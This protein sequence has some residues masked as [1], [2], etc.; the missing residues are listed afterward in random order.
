MGLDAV[1]QESVVCG[2][3]SDALIL[4]ESEASISA[5]VL[6]LTVKPAMR[7]DFQARCPGLEY[8][9]IK[10]SWCQIRPIRPAADGGQMRTRMEMLSRITG[11]YQLPKWLTERGTRSCPWRRRVAISLRLR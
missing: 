10:P 7:T 11:C 1:V 3:L 9:P 8:S 5:Q 4:D 2:F 6:L